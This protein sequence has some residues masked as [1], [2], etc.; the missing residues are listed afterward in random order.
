MMQHHN[1]MP[2]GFVVCVD[3]G[4]YPASLELHKIYRTIVDEAAATD[5]DF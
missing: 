5:G 4:E 2:T 1:E 3:N